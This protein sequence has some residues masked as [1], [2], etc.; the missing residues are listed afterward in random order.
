MTAESSP[1]FAPQPGFNPKLEAETQGD[2][3]YIVVERYSDL[4]HP[5]CA[6]DGLKRWIFIPMFDFQ[7]QRRKDVPFPPLPSGIRHPSAEMN[8]A[9]PHARGSPLGDVS[10]YAWGGLLGDFVYINLVTEEMARPGVQVGP[11][12]G[13]SAELTPVET[14]IP[15][16]SVGFAMAT[17]S[18]LRALGI[19]T[20]IDLDSF[21]L[22]PRIRRPWP[23]IGIQ[24]ME[25]VLLLNLPDNGA[26]ES[27]PDN[28][29]FLRFGRN[30]IYQGSPARRFQEFTK[31]S[32]AHQ[33]WMKQESDWPARVADCTQPEY[34]IEQAQQKYERE[35]H[36][37][38]LV[39]P[40]RYGRSKHTQQARAGIF[41]VEGDKM[42]VRGQILPNQGKLSYVYSWDLNG[43]P[44][45][46]TLDLDIRIGKARRERIPGQKSLSTSLLD[47]LDYSKS[48]IIWL[49]T[50]FLRC[51]CR[52]AAEVT[53]SDRVRIFG[54]T[55][56]PQIVDSVSIRSAIIGLFYAYL[57][58]VRF[59]SW[60]ILYCR[61]SKRFPSC[62]KVFP[63]STCRTSS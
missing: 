33:L 10:G 6:Q 56:P 39:V 58:T 31:T 43:K 29:L 23:V 16:D 25:G 19:W 8:L 48:P 11:M 51:D 40:V 63:T 38:R 17:R 9:E 57:T 46:T 21:H 5:P 45:S 22:R 26:L 52:P 36:T 20:F 41:V 24:S 14:S 12:P 30:N 49:Y 34:A 3:G 42:R 7:K 60:I 61:L 44:I 1:S 53:L 47:A 27:Q 62:K 15:F 2:V 28:R 59:P 13:D 50:C 37:T 18:Q 55:P 32:Y 35:Y 4:T 54:L